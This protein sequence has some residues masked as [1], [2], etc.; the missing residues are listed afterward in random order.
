MNIAIEIL[1]IYIMLA[2]VGGLAAGSII[3]F[4]LCRQAWLS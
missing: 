3:T 1:M 4:F 2:S